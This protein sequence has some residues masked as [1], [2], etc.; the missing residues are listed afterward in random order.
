MAWQPVLL[1]EGNGVGH[2]LNAS[3]QSLRNETL[4]RQDKALEAINAKTIEHN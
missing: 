3:I 1:I 2:K 4:N